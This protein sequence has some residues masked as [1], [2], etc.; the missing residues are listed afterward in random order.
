MPSRGRTWE[1]EITDKNT[2]II[3]IIILS[4][5]FP[6]QVVFQLESQGMVKEWGLQERW[7]DKGW[8]SKL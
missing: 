7:L 8:C 6:T 5:L 1:W 2:Q 4:L 3:E